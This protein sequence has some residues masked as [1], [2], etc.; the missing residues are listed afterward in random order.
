MAIAEHIVLLVDSSKFTT[1][2]AVLLCGWDAITGVVSDA[3]PPPAIAGRL[4][5]LSEG[6]HIVG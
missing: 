1:S 5:Q 2:A 6:V 3:P 4:A